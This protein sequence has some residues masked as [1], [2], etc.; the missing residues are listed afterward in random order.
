MVRPFA[1]N[2]SKTPIVGTEQ[3]G[4]I[5]IGITEQD[6]SSN[7]GGVHWFNGPDET[8]GFVLAFTFSGGTYP[9]ADGTDDGTMHFFRSTEKTESSL[10][11]LAGVLSNGEVT[12]R[13]ELATWLDEQGVWSAL[14]V[15]SGVYYVVGVNATEEKEGLWVLDSSLN[16]TGTF[17]DLQTVY[18]SGSEGDIYFD[19]SHPRDIKVTPDGKIYIVDIG[20]GTRAFRLNSDFT[21]D[22][23]FINPTE[24]YLNLSGT[25]SFPESIEVDNSGN[26]FIGDRTNT[27]FMFDTGGT[28]MGSTGLTE[29][30]NNLIGGICFYDNDFY[31][32]DKNIVY[33]YDKDWQYT[34]TSY[35]LTYSSGATTLGT[36]TYGLTKTPDGWVTTEI[37]Y[38]EFIT[39]D[40]DFNF[41]SRKPFGV[42]DSLRGVNY[43]P[44]IRV[45]GTT[46]TTTTVPPPPTTTTTST[47][48]PALYSERHKL[49]LGEFNNTFE[50]TSATWMNIGRDFDSDPLVILDEDGTNQGVTFKVPESTTSMNITKRE[51]NSGITSA[52]VE[53]PDNV[54]LRG[55]DG[56]G[57]F[58]TDVKNSILRISGL[59]NDTYTFSIYCTSNPSVTGWAVSD[60][61]Y[62]GLKLVGGGVDDTDSLNPIINTN[63]ITLSN[64][65]NVSGY[66]DLEFYG[67][68]DWDHAH[69][70]AIIITK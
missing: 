18:N 67:D 63:V 48:T 65:P 60:T 46:T 1:Y 29:L 41:V 5:A 14:D 62:V 35:S 27:V 6:Y 32:T 59:T 25:L 40:D 28:Y 11:E 36:N 24:Y 56:Y 55:L 15:S 49:N 34:N 68:Q 8:P 19:A 45:T 37:T 17:F 4:E 10:I 7:I 3:H 64:T 12:N 69:I 57:K 13:V 39:Y 30:N 21:I 26:M 23:T 22:E 20:Y 58:I 16:E 38:D 53:F 51:L 61:D 42:A 31:V 44:T 33:V 9:T 52:H 70:N 2:P 47:T 54:L 43:T 66:I 50:G